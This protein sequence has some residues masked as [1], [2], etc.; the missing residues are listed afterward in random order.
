M[1][2]RLAKGVCLNIILLSTLALSIGTQLE[3]ADPNYSPP[4]SKEYY[5]DATQAT[6]FMMLRLSTGVSTTLLLSKLKLPV[7]SMINPLLH[8]GNIPRYYCHV[9]NSR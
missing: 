8:L 5:L 7:R 1:Q 2:P 4:Q 9:E 6:T 3:L